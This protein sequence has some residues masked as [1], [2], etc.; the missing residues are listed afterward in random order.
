NARDAMPNGGKLSIATRNLSRTTVAQSCS[1]LK[2]GDY[3]LL[4]VRDTGCGMD[5]ATRA[6]IFEPFF[7]TK[8]VG[9]GTGLG[10]SVVYGVVKQSGGLVRVRSAPDAGSLFEIYLPRAGGA[11]EVARYASCMPAPSGSETILLVEDDESILQLLKDFLATRGYR[12]V[13]ASDG[14]EAVRWM[15]E[16]GKADLL[17]TDMMMPKMSGLTLARTLKEVLP[18]LKVVLMSGHPQHLQ[19]ASGMRFLEKPF[20]MHAL[21]T[22]LREVLDGKSRAAG[23]GGQS[24]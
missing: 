2:A 11:I 5:E 3:V 4:A 16:G 19:S 7:T 18:G 17:L 8:E 6:R 21:A 14:T 1:E 20:S 9:K 23:A 24:N 10:L 22:T 15:E 13:S 12:V